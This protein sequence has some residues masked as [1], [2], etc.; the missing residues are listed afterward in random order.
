VRLKRTPSVRRFSNL[1][2][3]NAPNK[4]PGA[5]LSSRNQAGQREEIVLLIAALAQEAG[6]WIIEPMVRRE[7]NGVVWYEFEGLAGTGVI[8][9]MLTRLGGV[10]A[11]PFDTLNLGHTVGDELK[12]VEEN[13]RRS[14]AA[15]E[16]G[17]AQ[18]VSP[19]QVHSTHVRWASQAHAGTVQPA[20]DGLL[21]TAPGVA[22]LLR[23]ADCVPILL[24]D[25]IH[26]AVGMIHSGWRSTAGNIAAAAVE[27]FARYAGS[28]PKDLWA[29]IGPAIGPCCYEVGSDIP[30]AITGVSPEGVEPVQRRDGRLYLDL[31]RLVRAQLAAAGVAQIEM[32]DVC[33]ACHTEEWFSHRAEDGRTGRFGA[34]VMLE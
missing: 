6:S 19:Y 26:R 11:P 20:A 18:V 16:I 30:E 15:L 21:T 4:L 10:S 33:T 8:H 27:A 25:P 22:L 3:E 23:F 1:D 17:R 12:A 31:P 7:N 34:L 28:R 9:A 5:R 29:G 32:A 24:F 14:L 13:H 2:R